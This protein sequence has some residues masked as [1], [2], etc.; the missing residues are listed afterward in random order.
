MMTAREDTM[1][2]EVRWHAQGLRWL[3][4]LLDSAATYLE[5]NVHEVKYDCAAPN[6]VEEVRLRAHLRG[7]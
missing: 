5:S 6:H 2:Y 4:G 3:A 7:L 1:T